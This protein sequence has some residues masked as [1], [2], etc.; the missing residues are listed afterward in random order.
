MASTQEVASEVQTMLNGQLQN[1][2][3]ATL[4]NHTL[5]DMHLIK[6][7]SWSGTFTQLP[8][9]IAGQGGVA[10]FDQLKGIQ[11]SK[12]GVMYTIAPRLSAIQ[13]A[14]VLA[15]DAPIDFTPTT[16]PNRLFGLCG[17]KSVIENITWDSIKTQ[18]DRAGSSVVINDEFSKI[19]VHA[20]IINNPTTKMANLLANFLHNP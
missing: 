5:V 10:R 4:N 11:G 9:T 20:T 17:P 14:V 12:G 19:A 8:G 13:Y 3:T 7:H 16:S 15:W 1:G 6:S 2:T 18:L